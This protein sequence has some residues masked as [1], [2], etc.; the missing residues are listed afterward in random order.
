M[1]ARGDLLG[2][3]TF[4]GRPHELEKRLL[5]AGGTASAKALSWEQER[6]IQGPV[7]L[8]PREWDR[9]KW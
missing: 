6:P 7:R 4:E 1:G 3:V 5:Q 2:K 8:Q 9:G